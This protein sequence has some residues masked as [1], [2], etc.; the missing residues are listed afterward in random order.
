M[1]CNNSITIKT[2]KLKK[3]LIIIAFALT[4]NVIT[5][6][7]QVPKLIISDKT[8]WHRIGKTTVNFQKEKDEIKIIGSNKFSAIKFKV[9]DAHINLISLEVY[10]SSG[11][12]QDINLNMHIKRGGE[13]KVI[14]LNSGER[15]LQKV[16]FIYKT[17]PNY[18]DKK[19]H[20]QLWGLKTNQAK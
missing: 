5:T 10:Y 4:A 11:D 13:S 18:K 8:G 15:N 16:V 17:M 7:A 6:T 2:F 20:V 9:L 12:R 3:A 1:L 14:D 19:A